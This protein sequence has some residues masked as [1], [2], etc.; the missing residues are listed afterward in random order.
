MGS[1]METYWRRIF[2]IGNCCLLQEEGDLLLLLTELRQYGKR[3]TKK[4]TFCPVEYLFQ[5]FSL[6]TFQEFVF[7]MALLPELSKKF[8][9]D[10][11]R[12]HGGSDRKGPSV[13]FLLESFSGAS[14]EALELLP[15]FSGDGILVHYL[16]ERRSTFGEP[17]IGDIL[18]L[19]ERIRAFILEK[20]YS[21][22]EFLQYGWVYRDSREQGS[23]WDSS[24]MEIENKIKEAVATGEKRLFCFCGLPGMGKRTRV[25]EISTHFGK[26]VYFLK[27]S[28]LTE[29]GS[30]LWTLLDKLFLECTL[31]G[32]FLAIEEEGEAPPAI[33]QILSIAAD[34]MPVLFYI[35]E[36]EQKP[37]FF[38]AEYTVRVYVFPKPNFKSRKKIW[39]EYGKEF[40]MAPELDFSVEAG[41]LSFT[42]GQIKMALLAAD[43]LREKE[44]KES[45]SRE[46]LRRGC[47]EQINHRLLEKAKEV[48][49]FFTWEDL[50]LPKKQTEKLKSVKNQVIYQYQVYEEWGFEKKFAYGLGT[51]I[52]F[53]GPPGTGKTMAAQV[54]AHELGISLFK[55]D[56]ALVVNKY[57]GETEKN[58]RF[59][60]EEAKKSQGML[61]FDEADVLFGKRTEVKD[62]NDKYSNMEAAFLLQKM[63]EYQGIVILATN[64]IQNV[65]EAFKRR[66][67]YS[68][69]FPF[70]NEES[71][72]LLWKAAFPDKAP[73]EELDY[74]FLAGAF[75]LSG[76]NIKNAALKSAFYSIARKEKV[77]MKHVIWAVMDEFEKSGK[78]ITR[79]ELGSYHMYGREDYGL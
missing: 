9:E 56:M 10:Y 73:K 46:L 74:E 57:I 20:E 39:E 28:R 5:I 78:K 61:F 14:E 77:S 8:G 31:T 68:I 6:D 63:E 35:R 25:K 58:L 75:E 2:Q 17:S 69:E 54:L 41:R 40:M 29:A 49:A 48:K 18:C 22:R 47:Q 21:S 24:C 34:E 50:V 53:S 45:I 55:V 59:I 27:G 65:D 23:F 43:R 1:S 11:A 15:Y 16:M 52:L 44:K 4:G 32:S 36:T 64:F 60:F 67:K 13:G 51:S 7:I 26:Q 3:L 37:E 76:S 71:R 72:F 66:I 62:S 38:T 79:E 19:K 42:P 70:P 30:G 12:I 33:G